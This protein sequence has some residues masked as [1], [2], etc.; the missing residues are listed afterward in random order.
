MKKDVLKIIVLI[1]LAGLWGTP[2]WAKK[3]KPPVETTSLSEMPIPPLTSCIDKNLGFAVKCSPRWQRDVRPDTLLFVLQAQPR[4]IVTLSVSR[5]DGFKGN[6]QD[7]TPVQLQDRFD[8]EKNFQMGASRIGGEKAIVIIGQPRNF[9]HVQL[10]DY[11]VLKKKVLYRI[12]FSVNTKNRFDDYQKL[13]QE[14]IRSFSFLDSKSSGRSSVPSPA[15][16]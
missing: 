10:L 7:L 9:P 14:L 3:A 12:S 2:V 8:Y 5:V 1:L 16:N 4:H 11:L 6:L 13:F 15:E